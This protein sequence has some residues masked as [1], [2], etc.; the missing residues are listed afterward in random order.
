MISSGEF[1]P[2]DRLPKESDLAARLQVSRNS[3]REAIRALSLI[4]IVDV[5]QGDGTY[6]TSMEP[7]LLSEAVSFVIDFHR[8]DK[9]LHLLGVRRVLEPAATALAAAQIG[10]EDLVALRALLDEMRGPGVGGAGAGAAP[11]A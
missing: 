10:E 6:V 7:E 1:R 9:I 11:P 3:L 8:A 4:H 2:G 5:R